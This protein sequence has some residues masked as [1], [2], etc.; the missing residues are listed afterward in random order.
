MANWVCVATFNHPFEA[1]PL[2]GL[3]ESEG[4]RCHLTN[5]NLVGVNPLVSNAVGGVQLMV[6]EEDH[7]QAKRILLRPVDDEDD[8]QDPS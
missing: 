1:Q 7:E 3:F 8:D 6:Q 2:K 4:I 5:E